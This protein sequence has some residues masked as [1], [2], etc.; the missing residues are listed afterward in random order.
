MNLIV[1]VNIHSLYCNEGG[2]S[3]FE[4]NDDDQM[5]SK[6]KLNILDRKFGAKSH[7]KSKLNFQLNVSKTFEGLSVFT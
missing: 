6:E 2:H 3:I 4:K 7:K 1:F 5:F